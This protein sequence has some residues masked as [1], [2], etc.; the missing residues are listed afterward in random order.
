MADA[1]DNFNLYCDAAWRDGWTLTLEEDCNA[2]LTT[3]EN[4]QSAPM[5]SSQNVTGKRKLQ[6]G[7]Y[8]T[9]NIDA[10]GYT[11]HVLFKENADLGVMYNGY[12]YGEF[13]TVQEG[14]TQDITVY[15]ANKEN[16][17]EY[18]FIYAGAHSLKSAFAILAVSLTFLTFY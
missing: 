8:C 18:E 10:T 6:V 2:N 12:R 11:A 4:F 16:E 5:F 1:W 7:E 15:N 13:I 17:I 14:T 3:C 9:I